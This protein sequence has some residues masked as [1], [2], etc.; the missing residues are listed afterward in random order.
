MER[1]ILYEYFGNILT[2]DWNIEAKLKRANNYT[3]IN[4]SF[5]KQYWDIITVP[6]LTYASESWVI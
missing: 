6:K 5:T 1:V 4:Y 2:E 3:K